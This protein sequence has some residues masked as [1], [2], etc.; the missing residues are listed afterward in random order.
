[1]PVPDFDFVLFGATGDLAARKLLPA[2]APAGS[3]RRAS[4]ATAGLFAP[5]SSRSATTN[6]PIACWPTRPTRAAV[7][8][9]ASATASGLAGGCERSGQLRR[10]YGPA[11]RHFPVRV[12]YLATAPTLFASIC[13][14]LAQQICDACMSRVV[15]E[16]PIG[17]DLS[18]RARSTTPSEAVFT[19]EQ[20][21]RID[22][23]L[24]KETVQNLMVL[25][26]ANPLFEPSVDRRRHRPCADHRARRTSASK[27][28]AATTTT[29]AR[30]VTW[31]RTMCCN[32]SA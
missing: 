1:M 29:P 13:T 14:N 30:C 8:L 17:H 6:S 7:R 31:F 2:L 4:L 12:F 5:A 27:A 18:P 19:E 10:P 3:R 26:F 28:E 16:K 25:R 15:L 32:F 9:N 24:G 23:Y 20:I 21:Y 22:H 11:G